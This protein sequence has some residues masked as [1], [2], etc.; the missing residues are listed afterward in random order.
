MSRFKD[1]PDYILGVTYEIWEGRQIDSLRRS[2]G[3]D[4]IM[5]SSQGLILGTSGVIKDTLASQAAFPD[6]EILG[7]D[8]IWCGNE[9]D[10]YLSSHRSIITG[11]HTGHGVFG[12]PTGR[13]VTVRCI[14]D[15][16][17]ENEVITDEWLCYDFASMVQQLGHT[18][19]AWARAML[20]REGDDP[21]RPFTPDQDRPGPYLGTGNDHALGDRLAGILTSI[22][23]YDIAVIRRE[24]DRAVGYYHA[25]GVTGWGYPALE[26]EWMQLRT[27]FPD[28]TFVV[29]HKIGRDDKGEPD[30]AAVRWSLDGH[31]T[32]HGKF[33]PPTGAPVHI[34][35]FTHAE[36]GRNGLRREW[37]I[38]DDVAIWKQIL[39]HGEK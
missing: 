37:S 31:H 3:P 5:R 22:M 39:M 29:Q 1:L 34:M 11:T 32:G 14:A 17:V 23:D 20:E 7:D 4:T 6:R 30:R 36:F 27:A 33:G 16:F 19:E 18:P 2:Y 15:C 38:W 28:A 21:I 9:E 25:G 8:V 24:Y 35:G 10:G 13:Q 26:A 12:A